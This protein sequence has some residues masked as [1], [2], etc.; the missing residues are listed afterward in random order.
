M[1]LILNYFGPILSQSDPTQT[2]ILATT[3]RT[4]P[5][6]LMVAHRVMIEAT[7]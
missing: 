1:N 2:R 7:D 6:I 4:D 5:P 3:C